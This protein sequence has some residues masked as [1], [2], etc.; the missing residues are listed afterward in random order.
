MQVDAT[1]IA[2]AVGGWKHNY[3]ACGRFHTFVNGRMVVC[4]FPPE[5][6]EKR[7]FL[8]NEMQSWLFSKCIQQASRVTLRGQF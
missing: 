7:I 3:E 8:L 5:E 2:N 1:A 4:M 6:L